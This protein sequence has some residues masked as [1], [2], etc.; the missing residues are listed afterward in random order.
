MLMAG[1]IGYISRGVVWL[2]I[3][4]LT[5]RAAIHASSSETGGEAKAFRFVETSPFG[6]YLLATLGIGLLAYGLFCFV[7][8][9]YEHFNLSLR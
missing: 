3:S 5:V 4:F 8:A 1:K 2:I 7:R 6:S 9:R